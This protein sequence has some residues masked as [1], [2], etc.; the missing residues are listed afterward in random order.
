MLSSR[1]LF[2][3]PSQL[4]LAD[5]DPADA[6]GSTSDDSNLPQRGWQAR[7]SRAAIC[8]RTWSE[9]GQSNTDHSSQS[10]ST[11]IPPSNESKVDTQPPPAIPSVHLNSITVPSPERVSA[12]DPVQDSLAEPWDA[13]KDTPKIARGAFD[14]LGASTTP[15]LLFYHVLILDTR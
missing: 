15:S 12:I 2:R 13:V 5:S 8:R 9:K 4:T 6:G 3:T 7:D 14:A 11:P 1:S 10:Q